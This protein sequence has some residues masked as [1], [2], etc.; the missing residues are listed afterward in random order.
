MPPSTFTDSLHPSNRGAFAWSENCIIAFGCNELLL[1][2]ASSD[3][4]GQCAMFRNKKRNF[5]IHFKVSCIITATTGGPPSML[6]CYKNETEFSSHR[7][8]LHQKVEEAQRVGP[9]P[10][11]GGQNLFEQF[12]LSTQIFATVTMPIRIAFWATPF[13]WLCCRTLTA[14]CVVM[15][16]CLNVL[17]IFSSVLNMSNLPPV[18]AQQK[19]GALVAQTLG[20]LWAKCVRLGVGTRRRTD[21]RRK[22]VQGQLQQEIGGQIAPNSKQQMHRNW[23][24]NCAKFKATNAQKLADKLRQIQSNTSLLLLQLLLFAFSAS[25]CR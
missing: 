8:K 9:V 19:V 15:D 10:V 12:I 1:R 20:Q 5:L 24:T 6:W 14:N 2:C 13:A 22:C 11:K 18:I 25:S 3:I 21:E 7:K 16:D 4:G 23:R 17:P